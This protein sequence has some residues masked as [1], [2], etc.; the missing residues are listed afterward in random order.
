MAGELIGGRFRVVTQVGAGGMGVVYRATDEVTGGTVAVK[1]V[2][3]AGDSDA[4]RF[5]REA[6]TLAAVTHPPSSSTWPTG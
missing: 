5:E 2:P 4:A 6:R 1:L 3:S